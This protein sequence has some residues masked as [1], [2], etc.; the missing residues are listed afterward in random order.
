MAN[1]GALTIVGNQNATVTDGNNSLIVAGNGNDTITMGANDTVVVGNGKDTFVLQPP[2]T[3][4]LAAPTNLSVNEDG[5]IALAISAGT[6]GFGFGNDAIFG[7]D[8][9]KDKIEFATSQFA[10]FAAV[11]AAAKQVGDDTVIT[12][13]GA[14]TIFLDDV[15]LSS[16]TASD[17]VFVNST[18]VTVTISGIPTGV[19]FSDS[20]GPLTVTNGSLTLTQA[21]L[22]GLTLKAGEVTA[23]TLTVKATDAVTGNSI[24]KTIALSVNPVAPTLSVPASLT[25]SAGVSSPSASQRRRSIR[26]TRCH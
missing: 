12:G 16:L 21:Q 10:N 4:T 18:N 25:V 8:A 7:F 17:F 22:A 6:T 5:S 20:A 24:T 19:S 9:S 3:V 2:G 23:G 13:D 26:A 1:D 11:M 14:D 15:R